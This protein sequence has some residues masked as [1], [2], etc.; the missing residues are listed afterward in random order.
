MRFGIAV[1]P[2]TWSDRDCAHAVELAGHEAVMLWHKDKGLRGADCVILPGGFSYGD[3][4]RTGAVARFAPL[5]ESVAEFADA[6]GLVWGICNGFQ[7]L[8]EAHMLPGALTRNSSL[9]F[10][11]EMANLR[12]ETG[13]TVYT[14]GLTPGTVLRVPVSHGEGRF[15]ADE[16]TLQELELERRVV[17]RYVAPDGLPVGDAT[18]NGSMHDIAGI[19]NAQR[20]V[21]GMMPHPERACEPLLGSSDGM[22]LFQAVVSGFARDG[23]FAGAL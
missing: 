12:V 18:P 23:V 21:L 1:F 4:L 3:Y 7:I 5:M 14:T 2:G 20:N 13:S 6:G 11:C 10:R 16:P 19:V 22:Q 15:V 9:E 8:C 17:F